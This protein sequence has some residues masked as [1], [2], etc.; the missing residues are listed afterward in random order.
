MP[1]FHRGDPWGEGILN[2]HP[3]PAEDR[4][5][6][7]V[8]RTP[9]ISS[10]DAKTA[11]GH[12][13]STLYRCLRA[14]EARGEVRTQKEGRLL[15]IFPTDNPSSPDPS[16][17]LRSPVARQIAKEVMANPGKH[18]LASLARIAK[19]SRQA[20]SSHLKVM[21]KWKL[22]ASA[23]SGRY[24]QLRPSAELQQALINAGEGPP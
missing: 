12:G 1:C 22:V 10:G 13:W 21:T 7:I 16:V 24:V 9:G 3:L 14:L 18:D 2:E 4:L 5:L 20:V 11:L 19:V 15:T 8:R 6:L 23:A 17:F